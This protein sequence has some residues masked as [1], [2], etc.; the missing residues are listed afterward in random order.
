MLVSRLTARISILLLTACLAAVFCPA[1]ASSGSEHTAV[2]IIGRTMAYRS[3][4]HFQQDYV[5]LSIVDNA[6]IQVKG[7]SS[8]GETRFGLAFREEDTMFV[9]DDVGSDGS[10]CGVYEVPGDRTDGGHELLVCFRNGPDSNY[11]SAYYTGIRLSCENGDVHFEQSPVYEENLSAYAARSQ[12]NPAEYLVIN[13]RDDSERE[14]IGR[15]ASDIAVGSTSDYER[16]LRIHDWVA[17]NIYYNWDAYWSDDPVAVDACGTLTRKMSVCH[18]YAALT[19][20][21]LR[22]VGIPARVVSGHALGVSADG[23]YWDEVDHSESNHSW[24]EAFVDGR[25]VILDTTWDS[26]NDYEDGQFKKGS[27]RHAYFDPSLQSFSYTHKIL[28]R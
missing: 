28:Q 3:S 4:D 13:I 11:Y 8:L 27:V 5:E 16:L 9:T 25:W 23:K 15:L 10:Y 6:M 14:K 26:G 21:L 22:G 24:N 18:G 2:S 1:S 20:A 17:E 19:E 7:R 12:L